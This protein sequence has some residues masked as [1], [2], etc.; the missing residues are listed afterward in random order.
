MEE[1]RGSTINFT[2]TEKMEPYIHVV[3]NEFVNMFR[4]VSQNL[5]KVEPLPLFHWTLQLK[6]TQKF[7]TR[8][9]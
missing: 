6:R 5:V 7:D 2:V 4:V 1:Q 8:Q 3:L 9:M